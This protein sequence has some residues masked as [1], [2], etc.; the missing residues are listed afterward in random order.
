[1]TIVA[2]LFEEKNLEISSRT[3]IGM[4]NL[5]EDPNSLAYVKVTMRTKITFIHTGITTPC[6]YRQIPSW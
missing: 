5:H 6:S 2:K 3:G 4:L 1:M